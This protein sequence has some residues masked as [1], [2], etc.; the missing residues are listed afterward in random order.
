M[1]FAIVRVGDDP[2]AELSV[3]PS[4]WSQDLVLEAEL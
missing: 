4:P 2:H 3:V 1:F